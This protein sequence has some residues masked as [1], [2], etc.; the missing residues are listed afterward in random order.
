VQLRQGYVS[1]GMPGT[2][3]HQEV[4]NDIAE[5]WADGSFTLSGGEADTITD[6]TSLYLR[7]VY[8]Q[9]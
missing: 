5:T 4:H 6:Y 8:N 1:E 3:I 7:F 9:A 2:Q